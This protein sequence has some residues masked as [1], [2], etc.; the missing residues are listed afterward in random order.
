M[1][2]DDLRISNGGGRTDDRWRREDEK[3]VSNDLLSLCLCR[4]RDGSGWEMCGWG[5]SFYAAK[6]EEPVY[7]GE[8][9]GT[10]MSYTF[11]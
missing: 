9:Q 4:G 10:R 3:I 8:E 6:E 5:H 1:V 2:L 7:V 11:K